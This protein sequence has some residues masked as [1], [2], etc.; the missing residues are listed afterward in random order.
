MYR[1]TAFIGKIE[2]RHETSS[3]SE[4]FEAVKAIIQANKLMFPDQERAI[5]DFF[6]VVAS[7]APDHPNRTSMF[8]NFLLRIERI[9][10]DPK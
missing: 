2:F 1:V 4:A 9:E 8:E 10:E 5:D 6:K 3:I 7:F